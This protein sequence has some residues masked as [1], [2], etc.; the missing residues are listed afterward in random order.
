MD[1]ESEGRGRR[2]GLREIG[3]HLGCLGIGLGGGLLAAAYKAGE[4]VEVRFIAACVGAGEEALQGI[5]GEAVLPGA[6]YDLSFAKQG[7]QLIAAGL[8]VVGD[9]VGCGFHVFLFLLRRVV[10]VG[11]V[12]GGEA[13][14]L[15]QTL[16][17]QVK[18][19][20]K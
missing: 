11:N 13:K 20:N 1:E 8:G 15:Q 5:A 4:G 12:R 7:A 16:Q 9:G 17:L 18:S 19:C 10:W 3:E 6:L 2:G 14:V